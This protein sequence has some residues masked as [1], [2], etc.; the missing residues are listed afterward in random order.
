MKPFVRVSV[1]DNMACYVKSSE[2]KITHILCYSSAYTQF[3]ALDMR[4]GPA[5][6]LQVIHSELFSASSDTNNTYGN[7]TGCPKK[8]CTFFK[9]FYF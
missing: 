4:V 1:Q 7:Y 2:Q 6:G 8:D 5:V 9:N 3:W